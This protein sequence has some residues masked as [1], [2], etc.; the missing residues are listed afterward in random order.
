MPVQRLPGSSAVGSLAAHAAA[1]VSTSLSRFRP[2]QGQGSGDQPPPYSP[3]GNTAQSPAP[4]PNGQSSGGEHPPGYTRVPAGAFDPKYLTDFQLD[5]LAHQLIGRITRLI[6]TE[7][8]MDRER[9]GRLRDD[10]G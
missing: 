1:T 2:Q 3:P 9:I 8:R 5:E 10:R 6:R 7:L 4:S